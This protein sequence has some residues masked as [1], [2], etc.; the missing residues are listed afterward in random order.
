M[1]PHWWSMRP[2]PN[3]QAAKAS[4]TCRDDDN[5]QRP[6]R[7]SKRQHW[8]R[9]RP[10]GMADRLLALAETVQQQIE[11]RKRETK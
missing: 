2:G 6:Y 1:T 8:E 7:Q 4:A 5:A 10:K 11:A 3:R 9:N